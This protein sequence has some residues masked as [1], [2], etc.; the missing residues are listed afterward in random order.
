MGDVII[1]SNKTKLICFNN[2]S[3]NSFSEST[4]KILSLLKIITKCF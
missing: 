1:K 3:C 2:E 4:E